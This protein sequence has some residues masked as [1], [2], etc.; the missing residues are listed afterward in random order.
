MDAIRKAFAC[1]DCQLGPPVRWQAGLPKREEMPLRRM[2]KTE[3][4]SEWD[5]TRKCWTI[6]NALGEEIWCNF[7]TWKRASQRGNA[8]ERAR[9]QSQ[10][11]GRDNG[12]RSQSQPA[13]R[14]NG[15]PTRGRNNDRTPR[16][17]S[18]SPAPRGRSSG[19]PVGGW[20]S[21]LF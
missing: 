12:P 11:A 10:P 20:T 3:Y 7:M 5:H 18:Q 17:R 2:C 6:T 15:P 1:T 8:A 4:E 9:S 21:R 14:D 16:G 19:T 13:G